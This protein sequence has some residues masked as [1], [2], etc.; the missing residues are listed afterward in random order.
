MITYWSNFWEKNLCFFVA[1]LFMIGIPAIALAQ[2][3]SKGDIAFIGFNADGDKDFAIVALHDLPANTTIY[4]TN[5]TWSGTGFDGGNSDLYWNT[6][7]SVIPAGTVITFNGLN[8]TNRSPS[9]GSFTGGQEMNLS[10]A[11]GVLFAY[12]GARRNPAKFLAAISTKED[13]YNGTS[14]TLNGTGLTLGSEAIL[15]QENI[16][17][18]QYSGIRSGNTKQGYLQEI[19]NTRD[20]WL[21]DNGNG[22]QS[23]EVLPFNGQAFKLV[24]APTVQFAMAVD[25]VPENAG[26][27]QL[28]IM[29]AQA[30][31]TK[32]S[33]NVRFLPSASTA[34]SSDLGGF[35]S[36]TINF[37][38]TDSSGTVKK[39][40]VTIVN[41]NTYQ[42]GKTA[43]FQLKNI[44]AGTIIKPGAFNLA[45]REVNTSPVVINE[46]L[47]DPPSGP[48]GDANGDGTRDGSGDEFIEIVNNSFHKIDISGW[49]LSDDGGITIRHIFPAGT[50]LAANQAAVVFGGGNPAGSFGGAIVQT[51]SSGLLNLVNGSDN[52]TLLD[53]QGNIVQSI[54]YGSEG[55]DGQSLTRDPDLTGHFVKYTDAANHVSGKLFSPGTKIDGNSF[56]SGFATAFRGNEGWRFIA[57][58][59]QN[60]TFDDLFANLWTQ[61]IPS[62]DAP[63]VAKKYA[64][65][66]SWSE[67]RASFQAI[68]GMK[69]IMA[70]G[71]GYILYVYQDDDLR[72]PGIQGGFPK[73]VNT[74]KDQNGNVTVSV[75]SH[76]A[77]G[78]GSIDG[79]EGYNLLGNPYGTD[80]SVDKVMNALQQIN[81]NVNANVYIWNPN[82]GNG[83][84]GYVTKT[85]GT[86]APF[87]AF[88]IRYMKPVSGNANFTKSAL[89]ANKG[90]KFYGSANM[91][92]TQKR[93]K[94]FLGNGRKFDTYQVHFQKNGALAINQLDAYKLFSLNSDPIE[95]Y[96]VAGD[97]AKL[98]KK[99]LPP[100]Q[101]LK[102]KVRI[103]LKYSMPISGSYKFRWSDIGSLPQDVQV[104]LIDHKT[105][106]KIDLRTS[107][108]YQFQFTKNDPPAASKSASEKRYPPVI[109][110]A[111]EKKSRFELLIVPSSASKG[112]KPE[113][114]IRETKML[115]NY[116]NPFSSQTT[117]KMQLKKKCKVSV[118]IYNIVGQKIATLVED[119]MM[120]KGMHPIHWQMPANMP[121][122]VYI[123][124]VKA[125]NK[126]LT[127][128][129]TYIK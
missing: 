16:D 37:S 119:K 106:Q 42:G 107:M 21:Q 51:A 86:I 14:G 26:S 18:G 25:T 60:T 2:S 117:V 81:P 103:P 1:C 114:E 112:Q 62:S 7:N 96:S 92:S 11:G 91:P 128:K 53:A 70:P 87:Q 129:M 65:I 40:S 73:T 27:Y 56:G 32:V 89:A 83:N 101:S 13:D 105:G 39:V 88:F 31:N 38:S 46:I 19:A 17:V 108:K 115:P 97:G 124:W 75:S 74:D 76:D 4:F 36:K 78:N 122:G 66:Y 9:I 90:T 41:D 109:S 15:L 29:L 47:A 100:L 48:S 93:V 54:S 50:V 30:N 72:N 59:T 33:V 102:E 111:A 118:I 79:N 104:Y 77:D 57:A 84:G 116:P 125:G 99:A 3:L 52:P 69:Q 6:G 120:Q 63:T 113:K 28:S 95:L 71:K 61:G 58:P 49:K 35:S 44:S 5:Q 127:Q 85:S 121:S 45:I 123:C 8:T 68:R 20:H 94:L 80:I 64:N 98:A 55:N 22:D 12:M 43:V 34:A 23:G 67:S 82:L 10:S 126:V 110:K 24:K